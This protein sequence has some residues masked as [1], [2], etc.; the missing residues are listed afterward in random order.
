MFPGFPARGPDTRSPTT[1]EVDVGQ[2][3]PGH[4][5]LNKSRLVVVLQRTVDDRLVHVR[6]QWFDVRI[7]QLL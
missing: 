4:L 6:V 5:R 7:S 3:C 2:K 1:E